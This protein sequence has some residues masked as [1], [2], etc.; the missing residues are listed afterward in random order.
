MI[1]QYLTKESIQTV[2]SVSDWKEA[3]RVAS[4]PLLENNAIEEVYV[5]NMIQSVIDNGPYIVLRDYFALAHAKAGEGV[6]EVGL[7]LLISNESVDLEGKPVNV[8]L[9]LAAKDST[10]HIE[11]LSEITEILM[12]DKNFNIFLS[13]NKEEILKI[14]NK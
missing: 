6:N 1:E 9:V 12:E 11:A 7:A 10:S 3:V 4:E 14:I 2:D 5:E 8:F 13:G